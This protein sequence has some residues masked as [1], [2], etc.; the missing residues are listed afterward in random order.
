MLDIS[1][2]FECDCHNDEHTIR[3]VYDKTE[4][5]L[6]LSVF[7]NQYRSFWNRLIVAVKYLFGYKCQYGH[8]DCWVMQRKDAQRLSGLVAMVGDD[9]KCNGGAND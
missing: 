2:Y 8:W 6:Y 1:H 7:L 4:N 5:E 9:Q 3:F